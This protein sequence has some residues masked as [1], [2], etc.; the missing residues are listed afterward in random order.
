VR[1]L[2]TCALAFLGA[3][4]CAWGQ[5]SPPPEEA[6]TSRSTYVLGPDD[7]IVI[8]A[9][10]AEEISDKPFRIEPDGYLNLPLVGRV[11]ASGRSV[12]TLES[13]LRT[14][15][16]AYYLKPEVTVTVT[17]LRSQPISVIGAVAN[18]GVQ[19]LQ[20]RKTLLQAIS[21]AGG[22]KPE[23]GQIVK[24]T[25]RIEWGRIPLAT[26]H[27]DPGGQFSI[28]DVN[29]RGLLDSRDPSQNIDMR[30]E[31]VISVPPGSVI[32]VIGEVKK[33]GGFVI[34]TRPNLTVLEALSMAE[35]LSVRA[36]PGHARI[37]RPPE[38]QD[39]GDRQQIPI[40]L[41]KIL[42]G[43]SPDVIL[44]PADILLVPNSA[45]KSVSIRSIEAAIQIGTGIAIW[46][47]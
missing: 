33:S 14:R 45:A 35:G 25:R 28:A 46:R 15:L 11:E 4:A 19:Q 22:L 31:D 29:L 20:G 24:I 32:Y 2:L 43:K 27:D 12:G 44:K 9:L 21:A 1:V 13:D 8:R 16:E 37:L 17:E 36:A 40:N 26:A 6:A 5:T 23:A 7:Q 42:A 18:P 3:G 10:H 47:F 34:G 38:N 30:P 39:G 41:T